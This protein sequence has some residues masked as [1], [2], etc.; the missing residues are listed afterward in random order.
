MQSL[1][2]SVGDLKKVLTN[3]KTRGS[4]SE[5]QLGN[6]LEQM[7]TP[8]Q[9]AKNI[10]PKQGGTCPVEF[11][12][13]F[14][15]G[16]GK[17]VWLPI[18]A[19]FPKEDYERLVEAQEK[20]D[21]NAINEIG[22][23]LENTIK[24]EAK[25]IKEKYIEPPHTTDVG[26]LFLGTE[27]LYAEVLRRP[28]LADFLQRKYRVIVTGPTTVAALLNIVQMGAQAFAIEQ[29][30]LQ[31]WELLRAVKQEF[32]KF[33]EILGKTQEKLRQ[34]SENIELAEKKSRTIENKLNKVQELPLQR[35]DVIRDA[36]ETD[37]QEQHN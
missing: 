17:T 7:L 15:V 27:G 34:A 25:D 20:G 37:V 24:N 11:A 29:R 8:D 21:I 30:A 23:S 9:Y 12:V 36:I 35:A 32:S 28:G 10:I 19:K 18:D 6:I 26:V 33:A 16:H 3:V 31:V 22:K 2:L 13:K 5:L 14:P 1:A 4:W